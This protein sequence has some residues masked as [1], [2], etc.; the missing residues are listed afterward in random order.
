MDH[1]I[2][3]DRGVKR[4]NGGGREYLGRSSR[5]QVTV[6]QD[7]PEPESERRKAQT[8]IQPKQ[9]TQNPVLLDCLLLMMC[10]PKLSM[11]VSKETWVCST[12]FIRC[13]PEPHVCINK[14]DGKDEA[15]KPRAAD[16]LG[17]AATAAAQQEVSMAEIIGQKLVGSTAY[18]PFVLTRC[19]SEPMRSV[20]KLAPEVCFWKNRNLHRHPGP[21]G[22]GF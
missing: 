15:K 2:L 6:T 11:E 8:D 20:S 13:L 21:L 5:S 19:K 10:E 7:R 18:E 1:L 17:L 3:G 14:K 4:V 16:Q 22:V 9:S 12:D